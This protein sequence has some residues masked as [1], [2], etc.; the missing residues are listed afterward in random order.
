[1]TPTRRS[2][3]AAPLGGT[4]AASLSGEAIASP[5]GQGASAAD[6]L[7]RY[8]GFGGKASGGPGDIACGDWM[9]DWLATRGFLVERLAFE[10]P[11]FEVDE[12]WFQVGETRASVIPQAIVAPTGPEG[13]GGAVLIRDPA[14]AGA[15]AN[16][17]IVV[18]RLPYGRWSTAG[19]PA[20]REPVQAALAAGASAVILVTQGPSGEALA[21]NADGRAPM[22]AAPVAVLAP[23]DAPA[24]IASAR[25]GR[26]GR[27]RLS[28]HG[29]RR[30]AFNLIGRKDQGKEQWLVVSTPRSGWFTCAGERGPGVAVW[31]ML[32][33]WAS[34]AN[35]P[36]NLAFACNSGHEYENLGADHLLEAAAPAP[37]QTRLWLHLGA[38]VAARDWHEVGGR[39][40]PLPS[41][42]PQRF[43]LASADLLA[44]CR[45]AFQGLAGLEAAYPLSAGATGELAHIAAAG[46]RRLVGVFGAHRFH[47]STSDDHR[48]VDARLTEEVFIAARRLVSDV[49]AI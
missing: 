18:L 20:V 12:A 13:I 33:D 5:P 32:A 19:A 37:D 7:E 38:N 2:L 4:L 47:H 6:L 27:L 49:S 3:L 29:G 11:F 44:P 40:A 9:A 10:A 36:V 46:Y 42:D 31:M 22:F 34:R 26:A 24:I 16:G 30:E 39:L 41:A 8:V 15:P 45:T 48:C 1:M 23:K 28:G 14:D 17:A 25:A 35:L 43:L 21:L